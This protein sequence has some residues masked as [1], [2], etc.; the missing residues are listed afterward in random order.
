MERRIT[1]DVSVKSVLTVAFSLALIA[2][3]YY[4]KDIL[5]LL[6]IAFILATAL[7][8][9]IDWFEK[10]KVP[11][12]IS[13]AAFYLLIIGIIF[14]L[15]RS[16]SPLV[17]EQLNALI[18]SR[19][20]IIDRL[21]EYF[22]VIPLSLRNAS[23]DFF[24]TLPGKI[25]SFLG[26]TFIANV[27]GVFSS[28]FA[29]LTVL[30]ASFYLLLEKNVM[31]KT[32]KKYWPASSEA[33]ALAIFKKIVEKISFWARGQLI[34]SSAVGVLVY[35][36]LSV[37]HFEFALILAIVAAIMDLLP[38]IGPAITMFLGTLLG[39]SVSPAMAFWV[40]ILLL[41][42]QQFEGNVLVPQIMKR[43][44]G[45]S[46][47]LIIFSI[48]I[49]ARLMGFIGVVIAVPIAS[50]IVVI[51]ESLNKKSLPKASQQA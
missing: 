7:E 34:L 9:A 5:L 10:K 45:L 32:I 13:I 41:G 51:I 22:R 19:Q 44:T 31:E 36:G 43:A 50:A 40:F 29:I 18:Q 12:G 30:V 11:R 25:E 37:L 24:N 42:V 47:V 48:L 16:V 26:G 6:L 1:F 14:M 46:P 4:I 27:F 35:I 39:F 2:V 28:I 15:V 3:L 38:F 8:P 49:G 21:S 17:S 33:Q 20:L 23:Q